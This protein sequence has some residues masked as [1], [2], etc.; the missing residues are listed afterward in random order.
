MWLSKFVNIA[1]FDYLNTKIT[2]KIVF[3]YLYTILSDKS[4]TSH[5]PQILI[6]C[7]KQD[8]HMAKG[9]SVI[10]VLLEKEMYVHIFILLISDIFN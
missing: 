1:V 10:K 5:L 4:I 3:R 6:L 7:N 2:I 8:L 9:S